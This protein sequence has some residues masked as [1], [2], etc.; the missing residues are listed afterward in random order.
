M[1]HKPT[2]IWTTMVDWNPTGTTGDGRCGGKCQA[3]H[4]DTETGWWAHPFKL[5]QASQEAWGGTGRK[6]MK[7][8]MPTD[9][10]KELLRSCYGHH[11][12]RKRARLNRSPSP[13]F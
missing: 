3:G 4:L 8:L 13:E 6:A 10:H 1:Y 2:H 9:L 7:N 12:G 11:R 5:A